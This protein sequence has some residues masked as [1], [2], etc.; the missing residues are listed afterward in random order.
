MPFSRN[1]TFLAPND[2]STGAHQKNTLRTQICANARQR[3]EWKPSRDGGSTR[4][5]PPAVVSGDYYDGIVQ[6]AGQRL[7]GRR[8][9]CQHPVSLPSARGERQDTECAKHT[10]GGDKKQKIY[11]DIPRTE[12]RHADIR[13]IC[14]NHCT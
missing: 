10:A 5:T 3:G 2:M 1:A 9:F 14:I 11:S 12:G 6:G 8:A 7:R 13:K 4:G